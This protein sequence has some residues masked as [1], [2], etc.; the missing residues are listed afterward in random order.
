MLALTLALGVVA[1]ILFLVVVPKIAASYGENVASRYYEKNLGYSATCIG[2]LDDRK[3]QAA[4]KTPKC[5]YDF[6]TFQKEAAAAY[7]SPVLFPGDL[8]MMTF[9]TAALAL[10]SLAFASYVPGMSDKTWQ[11]LLLPFVYW[12][13]DA[14]EDAK[15]AW[16]LRHPDAITDGSVLVLKALTGVKMGTA[17]MSL[18]QVAYLAWKAGSL[19]WKNLF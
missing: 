17:A 4:G 19:P 7:A 14:S 11:L 5:L 8:I 9:L 12:V 1:A 18:I 10:G 3:K 13:A 6:A 2:D 15:L 16:L